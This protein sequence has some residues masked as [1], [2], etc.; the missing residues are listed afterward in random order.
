MVHFDLTNVDDIAGVLS[1]TGKYAN[2]TTAQELRFI[3]EN[4][5]R[6]SN[7]VKFYNNG[8]EVAAPWIK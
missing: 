1:N 3:M 5:N 4:W 8:M 6:F 7:N 2:T